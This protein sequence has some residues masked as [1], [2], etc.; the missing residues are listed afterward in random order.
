MDEPWNRGTKEQCED[1]LHRI[2]TTEP[3]NVITLMCRG[4]I[5]ERINE[6]VYNKGVMADFFVDGKIP[7]KENVK[8]AV[9]FLLS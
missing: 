9:K 3:V 5:D 4:T 8:Q 2:G 1:R 7:K 6:I